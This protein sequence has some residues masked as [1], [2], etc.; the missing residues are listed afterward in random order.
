MPQRY[1]ERCRGTMDEAKNFYLSNN[2]TKYPDG[3]LNICKKCVASRIDNFNPETY[4]WILQE[5]DV[6]YV[7]NEWNKILLRYRDDKEKLSSG[8]ILGKYLSVMKIK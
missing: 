7:P 2:L 3:R 6:P 4:L 1:C 5:L 8:A